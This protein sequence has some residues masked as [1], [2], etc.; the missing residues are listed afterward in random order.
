MELSVQFVYPELPTQALRA[1]H[2]SVSIGERSGRC[3]VFATDTAIDTVRGVTEREHGTAI[4]TIDP[5]GEYIWWF[6]DDPTG[7]GT[8]QVQPFEGG[9][10]RPALPGVPPGRPAGIVIA[11]SGTVAVGIADSDGLAV[12]VRRPG[13]PPRCVLRVPGYGRLVGLS[14]D[15]DLIAVCGEPHAPDAVQ[16]YD[17]D[18]APIAQLSGV[19]GSLWGLAFRPRAGTSTLLSVGEVNGRYRPVLWS[20]DGGLS[21]LDFFEFDTEVTLSWFPDGLR[22]LVRQNRHARSNLYVLDPDRRTMSAISTP[23]GSIL[24]ADVQ[25]DGVLR[26]I[27]TDGACPPEVKSESVATDR[28]HRSGQ[29]TDVWVDGPGGRIHALLSLADRPAPQPAV[30]VLH[31]GPYQAAMDAYDPMVTIFTS[32]GCAVVRVNY[33]GS[34]G[35][36]SAW[37]HD[38][39]A[40][41]GLT[42]LED[43]AAVRDHLVACG[44]LD[45][46]RVALSGESWGGY[47]ALLAAGVLPEMWCGV[48]AVNPIADYVTAF[49]DTTPAVQ[50]LDTRLFGGRPDEVPH[51]YRQSSPI[52]YVGNVRAP[53]LLA[54]GT[55]DV[56][57]PPS[58]IRTYVEALS[59]AGRPPQVLWTDHGHEAFEANGRVAIITA[60]VQHLATTLGGTAE[61]PPD[62]EPQHAESVPVH[63]GSSPVAS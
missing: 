39:S 19:D 3:E 30:F 32:L 40:G 42:Q 4:C 59:L 57:C 9:L 18:G 25:P 31:G 35:Y 1:P 53:V 51:R 50:A 36:G 52:T 27:W 37:R 28:P 44:V 34:T 56:K 61:T 12:Y 26:Y 45:P 38:F 10:D 20:P 5:S 33:R 29:C 46:A 21:I 16:L 41:V 47:L 63:A 6:A 22:I 58:Q 54:A 17:A 60:V 13:A 8:W 2:R 24:A 43:I 49:R 14:A 48:A 62:D 11:L 15:G 55:A 23:A 7:T